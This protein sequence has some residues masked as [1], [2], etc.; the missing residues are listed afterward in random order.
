[1]KNLGLMLIFAV[2]HVLRVPIDSHGSFFA[3]RK[4]EASTAGCMIAPK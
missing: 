2:A 4:N 1:M 3:V